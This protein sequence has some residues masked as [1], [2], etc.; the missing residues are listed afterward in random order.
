MKI[1]NKRILVTGGTGF[2][3]GHL[4]RKLTLNN[5][6]WVLDRTEKRPLKGVIFIKSDL[7]KKS[8]LSFLDKMRFDYIFH[9]AG[10]AD[11]NFATRHPIDDFKINAG[12]TLHLLEKI[13]SLKSRPKFIFA[14]SVTVYGKCTDSKLRE[15]RSLTTPLSN[16]GVSKLTAERYAFVFARQ[17][18]IPAIS[19]RIFSTYGP[20]LRRQV[21]YDF[22][23]KLNTNPNQLEIL[24]D[25]SQARDMVYVDDQVKNIIKI[26][27]RAAYDGGVYNLCSGNLYTTK[28]LAGY[29]AGAMK[30]K[31]K[32]IFTHKIR[33]FDGQSWRGDNSIIKKMGCSTPTS[34]AVGIGKTVSWYM[35]EIKAMK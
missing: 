22:I 15:S 31:P 13:R 8:S 32:I 29:V 28:E 17:Y 25:G 10:N 26:A 33:T 6:V 2:I 35:R 12:A 30:I 16:Y 1:K 20:G 3:G 7:I 9:L 24:G 14:S 19:L 4:V 27:E 18:G 5:K 11:L 34:L 23:D 21:V